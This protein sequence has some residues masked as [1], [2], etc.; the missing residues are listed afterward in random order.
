MNKVLNID[1]LVLHGDLQSREEI[2]ETAVSEY[3]ED[4][5]AGDSFPAVLVY[6]DGIEYYLT[7]GYHRYH[8]HKR[9]E[10][11]GI[12]CE[13]V[14]GT[15]RDAILRST[16]ANPDH[17]VRRTSADKRKAVM[18]LLNDDEWKKW[19][20]IAIA[21]QCKVSAPLV[22]S[23]RDADVTD[24]KYK[25]AT[26]KEAIKKKNPG[27][28]AKEK[29]PEEVVAKPAPIEVSQPDAFDPRNELIEHLTKENDQLIMDLALA[30]MGGTEEEKNEAREMITSLREE[31]RLLNIEL[32]AVKINR[33]QYQSE[34]S[35]LK[36]QVL[37]MQRQIKKL[38]G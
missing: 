11:A 34:N 5:K 9:A 8:A 7:D 2:S 24:V 17:G 26:G 33:D 12:L 23:L 25:T 29:A 37:A 36:K 6:F 32:D 21:K 31:V 10:K 14:N 1:L 28:V 15:Y 3:A 27:R 22:A 13:V 16:G 4:I 38:E 30:H 20:N 35:Q 19:S 18:K